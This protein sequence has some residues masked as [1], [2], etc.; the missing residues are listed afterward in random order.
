MTQKNKYTRKQKPDSKYNSVIIS[1]LVCYVMHDGKKTLA[2]KIVYRSCEIIKKKLK[3]DDPLKIIEQAVENSSPELE[4]KSRRLGGNNYQVPF[5]VSPKKKTIYALRWIVT[6]AR[7]HKA[8]T[9]EENLAK[10]LIDAA[11]NTGVSV[12]RKEDLYK[13][14]KAN[15]AFAHYRW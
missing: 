10:E 2:K 8:H 9:M 14:A 1:K 6:H 4:L 15:W 7:K 11:N 13:A 3:T 5:V 12:K